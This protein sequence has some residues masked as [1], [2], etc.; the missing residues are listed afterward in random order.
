M[1]R[2]IIIIIM[3]ENNYYKQAYVINSK[4]D[5]EIVLKAT[6]KDIEDELKRVVRPSKA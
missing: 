3:N 1:K 4:N 2:I 6:M 5:I